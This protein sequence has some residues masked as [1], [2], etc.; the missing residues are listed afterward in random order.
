MGTGLRVYTSWVEDDVHRTPTPLRRG[1]ERRTSDRPSASPVPVVRR[2]CG[3]LFSSP[4]F[5]SAALIALFFAG[6]P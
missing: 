6:D 1:P 4:A 5:S 2:D 3:A